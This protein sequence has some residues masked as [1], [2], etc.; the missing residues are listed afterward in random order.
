MKKSIK[1]GSPK[2]GNE[3]KAKR[4]SY[5]IEPNNTRYLSQNI[6]ISTVRRLYVIIVTFVLVSLM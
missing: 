3:N 1:N 4:K 2:L 5:T 6:G